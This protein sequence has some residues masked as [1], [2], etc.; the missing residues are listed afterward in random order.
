[1]HYEEKTIHGVTYSRADPSENWS[2]TPPSEQKSVREKIESVLHELKVCSSS[3][4]RDA[5]EDYC[6]ATRPDEL[7]KLFAEHT[8]ELLA[9][10]PGPVTRYRVS[11]LPL[12]RVVAIVFNLQQETY[13]ARSVRSI[14]AGRNGYR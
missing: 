14:K 2:V 4:Y 6:R 1:M 8:A 9:D 3:A 11:Y 10:K 7:R 13:N 12:N 5:M